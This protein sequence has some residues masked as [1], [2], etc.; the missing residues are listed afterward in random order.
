MFLPQILKGFGSFCIK[1]KKKM[2][3][4]L[5]LKPAKPQWIVTKLVT[6]TGMKEGLR[7]KKEWPILMQYERVS[8]NSPLQK[9]WSQQTISFICNT[10]ILLGVGG[11]NKT[12]CA[13]KIKVTRKMSGGRR[14]IGDVGED[15][16]G[17]RLRRNKVSGERR[18]QI[19]IK[20]LFQKYTA[21]DS[22]KFRQYSC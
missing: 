8:S 2:A 6:S 16:E 3:P 13:K 5:S 22:F 9:A 11:K 1:M 15:D 4:Q 21:V 12:D 19:L 7:E 18:N 20:Q 10:N 14:A 17:A